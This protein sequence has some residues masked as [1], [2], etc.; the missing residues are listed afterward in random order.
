M[1]LALSTWLRRC[2]VVFAACTLL[3]GMAAQAQAQNNR[4]FMNWYERHNMYTSRCY[5]QAVSGRYGRVRQY[6]T[7]C[8]TN[9]RFSRAMPDRPWQAI[10]PW[11]RGRM[12]DRGR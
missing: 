7:W 11:D 1:S 4:H 12:T 9:R 5:S 10:Y 2:M 6:D 8:A 3:A